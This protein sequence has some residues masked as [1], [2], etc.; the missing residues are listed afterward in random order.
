MSWLRFVEYDEN[1]M[2]LIDY[3]ARASSQSHGPESDSD[4]DDHDNRNRGFKAKDL[5]HLS[6]RNENKVLLRMKLEASKMIGA[7]PTTYEEDLEILEK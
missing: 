5:P 7:Y 1:I 2:L 3:Q 6:V 4:D